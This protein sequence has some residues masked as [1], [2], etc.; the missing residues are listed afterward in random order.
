MKNSLASISLDLDNKWTYLKTHGDPSWESFPSYLDLV[1]PRILSFLDSL[2]LSITFFVVGQDAELEKNQAALRQ[3]SDAGHE[4]ANHSFHHEPWLHLYTPQQLEQEFERSEAAIEQATGQRTTGFRGPGFSLSDEVLKILIRRGYAYDCST[5]PTFLGPIA[6]SY[7]F[8]Q[9]SLSKKQKEERKDLFGGWS[10]GFQSNKPFKWDAADQTLL[11]IPV[12]TMPILRVPIHG[13]YLHFL[14]G[15]SP[16]LAKT[17]FASAL[18]LCKLTGVEPSFLLHP[19][20]FLGHDDDADLKFFPAMNQPAERKIRLMESCL[21]M[22]Q[23]RFDVMPIG[24][25]ANYNHMPHK[26]RS[27]TKAVAGAPGELVSY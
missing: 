22:F 4:I 15:V 12:T 23:T 27:V 19:L 7:C 24:E 21:K 9:S 20:D 10:D 1:V 26:N 18:R 25:Y 11:E 6:R 17:Y 8:L 3:I 5:F 13:T 16:L 2:D 14:G